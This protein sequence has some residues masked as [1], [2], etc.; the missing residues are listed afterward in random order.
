[1]K[2]LV[3]LALVLVLAA[4]LVACGS[5]AAYNDAVERLQQEIPE[6]AELQFAIV[7]VDINNLKYVNDTFGHER[8]DG[9]IKGC[10]KIVCNLFI[11]YF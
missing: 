2:R 10:C 11:S 6:N 4:S 1:M 3:S 7:M 8:G 5:K 9:Y